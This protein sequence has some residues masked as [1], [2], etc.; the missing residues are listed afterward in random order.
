MSSIVTPQQLEQWI[1]T[2]DVIAMQLVEPLE[3]LETLDG[4][5]QIVYPPTYA[6]IGYNVDELRDK[7]KVALIDSVGSQA[8][9]MEQLFMPGAELGDLVPQWFVE[10]PSGARV[11]IH[12]LA[13]RAADATVLA[14]AKL[15]D[16]AAKAFEALSQGDAGPMC[17]FAPTSLLFGVW[18]SRGASNAKRPR[19]VRGV[20][21]ATDVEPL[22]AAAQFN[23]V[24]KRLDE[25]TRSELSAAAGKKDTPLSEKG[26]KDAPATFRKSGARHWLED[27]KPN[28]EARV[29][30]GVLVRGQI[31]RVVTLNFV[32]LRS[33]AAGDGTTDTLRRY[34]GS[35]AT[36]AASA[37]PSPYLR[38]GCLLRRAEQPRWQLVRRTGPMEEIEL[39]RDGWRT[40]IREMCSRAVE[41]FRRYWPTDGENV[42]VFDTKEAVALVKKKEESNEG[43]E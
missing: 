30:G 20:I 1:N 36:L 40:E 23:S 6:D 32:S 5:T 4:E 2:D 26:F 31:T 22:H 9:R 12:E 38:E 28:P 25:T 29:L 11:S 43:G 13:H 24:W 41:P 17:G 14:T 42:G 34:L 18:D 39:S 27:G 35:L 3:S 10:L 21:R 16:R 37:T 33:L 7:T 19:I 8:N 15:K